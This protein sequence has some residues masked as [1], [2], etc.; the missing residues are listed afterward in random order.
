MIQFR[1]YNRL[2]LTG[3]TPNHISNVKSY[4]IIQYTAYS[5]LIMSSNPA[6]LSFELNDGAMDVAFSLNLNDTKLSSLKIGLNADILAL[7]SST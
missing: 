3:L 6:L 5:A 7:S 2:A 1:K 4:T